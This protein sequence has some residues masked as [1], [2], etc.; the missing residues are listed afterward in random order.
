MPPQLPPD[1]SGPAKLPVAPDLDQIF[2]RVA[3][4]M[5][6]SQ[7]L[8]SQAQRATAT[9][10]AGGST[11]S[12][13][14]S[15]AGPRSSSTTFS[16]RATAP[17][18]PAAAAATTTAPRYAYKT[19]AQLAAED[20]DFEAARSL[21]PNAG[22]GSVSVAG[23]KAAAE[24]ARKQKDDEWALRRKM[25]L[26]GARTR[27][28]AGAAAGKRGRVADDSESEEE[29]GRTGLGRAKK[30]RVGRRGGDDVAGH[31]GRGPGRAAEQQQQQQQQGDEESELRNAEPEHGDGAG[32]SIAVE[33]QAAAAEDMDQDDE[34]SADKAQQPAEGITTLANDQRKKKNKKKK[35]KNQKA[36]GDEL[37]R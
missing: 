23:S 20:A 21:P 3:L 36:A 24:A 15:A 33:P 16:S 5:S 30:A 13:N 7:R 26:S 37:D 19:A 6:K 31:E 14:A 12:S 34:Q 29:M 35:K 10:T 27:G 32:G 11:T 1:K 25:G 17:E 22:L 2:N 9:T 28:G 18:P 8:F 4:A